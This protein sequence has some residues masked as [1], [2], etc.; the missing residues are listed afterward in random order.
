MYRHFEWN[1]EGNMLIHFKGKRIVLCI[2]TCIDILNETDS[3][4]H[5]DTRNETDNASNWLIFWNLTW[6][7]YSYTYIHAYIHTYIYRL[8]QAT[9]N[10]A[11]HRFFYILEKAQLR[12]NTR[13]HCSQTYICT[14]VLAYWTRKR[15]C[16]K[17][18]SH[19]NK[20]VH[21]YNR[22]GGY[23]S[24]KKNTCIHQYGDTYLGLFEISR[25][26][27]GNCAIVVKFKIVEVV[28]AVSPSCCLRR[29]YMYVCYYFMF[30]RTHMHTCVLALGF[31]IRSWLCMYIDHQGLLHDVFMYG[32]VYQHACMLHD[33]HTHTHTHTHTCACMYKQ[34]IDLAR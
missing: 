27:M 11:T 18:P 21:V 12:V 4:P 33:T 6:F 13:L 25:D 2:E 3:G 20:F 22:I 17:P 31:Y 8:W 14:L 10:Q 28:E 23:W 30:V 7:I 26:V 16:I 19:E 24:P 29:G 9:I 32:Y 1:K 34:V 5:Q 15:T